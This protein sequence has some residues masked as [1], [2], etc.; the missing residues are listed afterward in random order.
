MEYIY[1]SMLKI[2]QITFIQNFASFLSFSQDIIKPEY[3]F[4]L[5]PSCTSGRIDA[6]V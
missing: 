5:A 2:I 3:L 4:V 1:L 6:R